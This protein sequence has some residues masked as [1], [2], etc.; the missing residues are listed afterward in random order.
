MSNNWKL[1]A[2]IC[3]AVAICMHAAPHIE[4]QPEVTW[5][6]TISPISVSGI[7]ENVSAFMTSHKIVFA[8]NN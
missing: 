2:A 5:P 4:Q 6:S 7:N 3:L 1:I 8:Q